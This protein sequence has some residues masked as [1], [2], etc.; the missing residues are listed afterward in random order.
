[1][2][3]LGFF[4][5]EGNPSLYMRELY[6]IYIYLYSEWGRERRL[7]EKREL[8]RICCRLYLFI[9]LDNIKGRTG[10]FCEHSPNWV[11]HIYLHLS[12][13]M[14]LYFCNIFYVFHFSVIYNFL[15]TGIRADEYDRQNGIFLTERHLEKY[16]CAYQRR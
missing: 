5:L 10:C 12:C 16:G 4:T 6:Y 8:Q 1:M 14:C 7:R 3:S 15:T 13:F 11:N 9:L 2:F